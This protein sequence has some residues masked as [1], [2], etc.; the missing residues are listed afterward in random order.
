VADQNKMNLILIFFRIYKNITF[1]F[2]LNRLENI[3]KV[4]KNFQALLDFLEF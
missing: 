1:I 4:Y 3:Y 2:K